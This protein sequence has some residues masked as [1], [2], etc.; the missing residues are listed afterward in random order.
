M[1]QI[2]TKT[3]FRW[4]FGKKPVLAYLAA[5]VLL[6]AP[7]RYRGCRKARCCPSAHLRNGKGC[8]A[9]RLIQPGAGLP[10]AARCKVA[11]HGPSGTHPSDHESAAMNT[12][13]T[14]T[15]MPP[16]LLTDR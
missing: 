3:A 15:P 6:G 14:V 11:Y 1:E 7:A 16:Q 5:L 12:S 13:G 2:S 8:A 9:A 10:S 4:F